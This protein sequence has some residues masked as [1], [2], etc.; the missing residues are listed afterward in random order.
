MS[1]LRKKLI[2]LAHEDEELRPKLLPLLREAAGMRPSDK[3]G[4]AGLIVGMARRL[5]GKKNFLARG[6]DGVVITRDDGSRASIT[7]LRTRDGISG[8]AVDDGDGRSHRFVFPDG[9]LYGGKRMMNWF[10][11][12][13]SG[14]DLRLP[15]PIIVRA[16]QQTTS[17]VLAFLS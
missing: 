13:R 14:P 9:V 5:P 10:A 17:N 16:V 1:D 11:P 15:S 2:R 3:T 4:T 12:S 8:F 7:P 6:E